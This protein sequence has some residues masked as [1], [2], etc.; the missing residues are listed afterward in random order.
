MQYELIQKIWAML[1]K[2]NFLLDY[3]S[4]SIERKKITVNGIK[5]F[6]CLSEFI[7]KRALLKCL[8]KYYDHPEDECFR[9]LGFGYSITDFLA[10]PLILNERSGKDIC[11]LGAIANLIIT[12]FDLFMDAGIPHRKLLTKK[13]L[14]KYLSANES[15]LIPSMKNMFYPESKILKQ[16]ILLYLKSIN[17]TASANSDP[18][19]MELFSNS[20]V[21]MFEAEIATNKP[22]DAVKEVHLIRKSRLPFVLKGLPCWFIS[23]MDNVLFYRHVKWMMNV[24]DFIGLIDDAVDLNKD[25]SGSKGGINRISRM[26]GMKNDQEQ[27]FSYITSQLESMLLFIRE[28]FNA[29]TAQT[30]P[31]IADTFHIFQTCIISW[32]GGA[33]K[34]DKYT[35]Q[36]C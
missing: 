24:G 10:A 5:E 29:M 31:N 1:E 9:I 17:E 33:D 35:E 18:K 3:E 19:L 12:L 36:I 22:P 6:E 4:Y 30:H 13:D 27:A 23:E 25:I 11:R 32:F 21:K 16:I 28:E 15:S 8:Q 7:S 14:I 20:I 2:E 26:I 34:L